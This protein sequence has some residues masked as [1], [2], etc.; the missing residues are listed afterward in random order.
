M[1]SRDFLPKMSFDSP[2]HVFLPRLPMDNQSNEHLTQYPIGNQSEDTLDPKMNQFEMFEFDASNSPITQA[3]SKGDVSRPAPLHVNRRSGVQSSDME[4]GL[5]GVESPASPASK[6]V[7]RS[8]DWSGPDD[9][10]NP[11]NWSLKQR[12]Y[13]TTIPGVLSF[14]VTFGSSVYTP[15]YFDVIKTFHVSETVAVLGLSLYVLGLAFGPILAAPISET[16]GRKVVYLFSVPI[17]ACFTLGAGWAQSFPALAVCRFFAGFFASPTLAVG[18]GTNVDVWP[19]LQR[20]AATSSFLLAP[21]AGPALGPAAGGFAAMKKGWRW[22]QWVLL[23]AMVPCY[24]YSLFMKETYKKII[25]QKRAKK[26]GLPPSPKAGPQGLAAIKFLL[27]VTLIRPLNMLFTEPIVFLMSI[28]VAFNF[29]VLF[30]FFDSFPIV[31]IGVYGMNLGESGLTFLGIGFGCVLGVITAIV[32]DRKKFH[33]EY[34]KSLREGR[35]GIVAP[36]HR[37]YVAMMGSFGMPIGLFWFAWTAKKDIHWISP[38][39]ATVPFAWGN[40][41]I[42]TATA[43]YLVDVYGPLNGASAL[44][45]NGLARYVSGAVFPL[46]TIQSKPTLRLMEV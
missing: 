44:A 9:P 3:D 41:C 38:V 43:S 25:L 45:A 35:G 10:D 2:S 6:G 16:K 31:F 40:L 24:L 42:F 34:Y 39:L 22:T 30:A 11:F 19:A 14:V 7:I 17:A 1:D 33:P 12:I 36:E 29:S 32:V 5:E 26:L 46:F 21:F 20:A 8:D 23:F 13:H 27:T 37:L 4:K 15:G 18:A 28:Y